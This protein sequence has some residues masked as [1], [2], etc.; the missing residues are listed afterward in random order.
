MANEPIRVLSKRLT[1]SPGQLLRPCDSG[2][3]RFFDLSLSIVPIV[4]WKILWI[5]E[6]KPCLTLLKGITTNYTRTRKTIFPFLFD[7]DGEPC[8]APKKKED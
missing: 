5:A 8:P 7:A 3:I 6:I 2:K 4:P 1:S